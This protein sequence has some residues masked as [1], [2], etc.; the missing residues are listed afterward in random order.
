LMGSDHLVRIEP[1]QGHLPQQV[2]ADQNLGGRGLDHDG[3]Q[4]K[5]VLSQVMA[6]ALE[7]KVPGLTGV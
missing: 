5:P 2:P 1:G 3:S 6:A 4:I 7:P